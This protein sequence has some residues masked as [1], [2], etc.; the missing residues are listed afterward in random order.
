MY[1]GSTNAR[2]L[3]E[4]NGIDYVVVGPVERRMLH[5]NLDFFARYP[6]VEGPGDFSLYRITRDSH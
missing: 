3:L 1:A 4:G 5:P 6:R 2:E